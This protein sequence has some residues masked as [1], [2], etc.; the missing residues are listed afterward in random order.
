MRRTVHKQD[1]IN[2]VAVSVEG[3]AMERDKIIS[4]FIKHDLKI[5]PEYFEAVISGRKKFELRKNDRDYKVGDLFVLR[6]WEPDKGYTGRDFI[7][8]IGYILKDC[9]EYGLMDGYIIFSW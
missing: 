7:Q 3:E 1:T 5:L 2:A 8:S 9:P 6:E 4:Q